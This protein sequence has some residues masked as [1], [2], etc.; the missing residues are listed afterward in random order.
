VSGEVKGKK[1]KVT[2]G[3]MSTERTRAEAQGRG[4]LAAARREVAKVAGLYDEQAR[5]MARMS[6]ALRN[7]TILAN[8]LGLVCYGLGSALKRCA[9]TSEAAAQEKHEA[10]LLWRS[11]RKEAA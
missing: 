7:F 4:E 3:G 2:G 10:L 1:W 9:A 6:V 5:E 11:V 8:R